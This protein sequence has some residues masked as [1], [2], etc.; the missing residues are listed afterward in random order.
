MKPEIIISFSSFV[1]S[2]LAFMFSRRADA[3]AKQ[4]ARG[5]LFLELRSRFNDIY[6]GLPQGYRNPDWRAKNE[7]EKHAVR[8]YWHH[9]FDEWYLTNC[10]NKDNMSVLWNDY[11]SDG[12][13]AGAKYDGMWEVLKELSSFKIKQKKNLWK[14]FYATVEA[15]RNNA[16]NN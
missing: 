12:I 2:L 15:L 1:V 13:T 11:F 3:R 9:C 8:R 7:S 14:D 6:E 10:L 5:N 4:M 16:L